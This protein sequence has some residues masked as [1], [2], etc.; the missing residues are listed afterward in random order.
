MRH[1]VALLEYCARVLS[2]SC[3]LNSLLILF[4]SVIKANSTN[5]NK[6]LIR[7]L[8]ALCP[9]S[10][11]FLLLTPSYFHSQSGY[12]TGAATGATGATAGTA[13]GARTGTT[14]HSTGGNVIDQK[15]YTSTEDRPVDQEQVLYPADLSNP[16]ILPVHFG[17]LYVLY[18]P[19]LFAKYST[20][21]QL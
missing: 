9:R 19:L 5:S 10:I 8:G 16:H 18:T 12:S 20:G 15:Y 3:S 1:Q 21:V 2:F 14:G 7:L 13:T 4:Y 11:F 17:V 6:A